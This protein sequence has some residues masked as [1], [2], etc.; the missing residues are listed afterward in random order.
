M[1]SKNKIQLAILAAMSLGLSVSILPGCVGK[2]SSA[3]YLA[4]AKAHHEKGRNDAAEIELKNLFAVDSGNADARLLFAT[5]LNE[6]GDGVSAERELRKLPKAAQATPA[7]FLELGRSLLLQNNAKKIID[8]IKPDG[9]PL[10]FAAKILAIRGGAFLALRQLDDA[11]RAFDE[12]LK[13]QPS[14]VKALLGL[15]SVAVASRDVAGAEAKVDQAL[16]LAPKDIDSLLF[17]GD[18]LRQRGKDDEAIAVYRKA[19]E[20]AAGQY[21]PFLRLAS[22]SL[23]KGKL[24]E[25]RE[26]L[27]RVEKIQ[28]GLSDARY[29]A[30][31]INFS[32]GKLDLAQSGIQDVLKAAPNHMASNLLAG[33][34]AERKGYYSVAEAHLGPI[35]SAFPTNV[36]ARRLLVSSLLKSGQNERALEVLQRG[37]QLT[38]D[39]PELLLQAGDA[40]Y[41][42]R[43]YAKA[44]EYFDRASK[45]KPD[46]YVARA[47]LGMSRLAAGDAERAISELEAVAREDKAG[48]QAD[49]LLVMSHLNRQEFDK[50][51]SAWS[52]LEKKQPN[53]PYTYAVKADILLGK[54]DRAGAISALEKALQL[55]PS[56]L[57]AAMHLVALDLQDKKPEQARKRLQQIVDQDPKNIGAMVALAGFLLEQPG[58]RKSAIE[59]LEK[60]H[61]TQPS[62]LQPVMILAEQL[63]QDG[64]KNKALTYAQEAVAA[65]PN[66]PDAL[67]LLA[68]L[69]LANDQKNQALASY[70]KLISL[71]PSA[72]AYFRMA[73]VQAAMSD[74]EGAIASLRTA[75]KLK[76]DFADAQVVLAGMLAKGGD[77]GGALEVA[78]AAQQSPG[79]A[80]QGY[81]LEG[82]VLAQRK[83]YPAAI[84]SYLKAMAQNKGPV[85]IMK[86]Y[87]TYRLNGNAQAANDVVQQW[88]K[89][90]PDDVVLRNFMAEDSLK[91][92]NYALAAEYYQGLLKQNPKNLDAQ[93]NLAWTYQQLKDPRA[94]PTAEA[95]YKAAPESPLVMDTLAMILL[96]QGEKARS[97]ELLQKA[98]SARPDDAEIAAHLALALL[99]N[100]K[101]AEA[102]VVVEKVQKSKSPFLQRAEFKDL[103]RQLAP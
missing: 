85:P 7:Y 57:P 8:D 61:K 64:N 24:A 20:F 84:A 9:M 30:A 56:F 78:K 75:V 100:G 80:Y 33:A 86:L 94:L 17:K 42:S 68:R 44:T 16:A 90:H 10:D 36:Y 52:A 11:R 46:S 51:L 54:Q 5:V 50:A 87:A 83:T 13:L 70:R 96:A 31:V 69:E 47:R 26:Y 89:N 95:A 41:Q 6:K 58:Q 79:S 63:M 25:A 92:G 34:I 29:Y 3:E 59:W 103:L 38:P 39:N 81:L 98:S 2:K 12:A 1:W 37:L 49:Y 66:N 74:N 14:N 71:A 4:A 72:Q 93:N 65:Q 21:A 48:A 32:E 53:S 97:L 35:V 60:A 73:G 67:Y 91:R 82:D 76:P 40:Y 101:R 77:L 23:N 43:D 99:R 19:G 28:P 18:L 62:A 45:L 88:L 15:A 55:Q 102:Q 22:M 27:A